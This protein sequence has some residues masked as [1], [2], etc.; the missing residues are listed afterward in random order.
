MENKFNFLYVFLAVEIIM[1][2]KY[3]IEHSQWLWLTLWVVSI[4]FQYKLVSKFSSNEK[5]EEK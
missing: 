1:A 3:C 5:D 2:V 4:P